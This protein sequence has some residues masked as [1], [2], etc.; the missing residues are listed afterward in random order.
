[1]AVARLLRIRAALALAKVGDASGVPAL[2]EALDHCDD[3]LLWRLILITLGQLRDRRAVPALLLHL[4]E[5]QNRREMVDA[6]GA[7]GDPAACDA[8]V[9]RLRGDSYVPVRVQAAKA[10]AKLGEPS[11]I[12]A[13]ERAATQ[14]TEAPVA[15]AAREA[16]AALGPRAPPTR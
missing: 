10:L 7:I 2:N 4:P 8:L 16:L 12:P 6:L 1:P 9:E 5:V 3:V 13:L 11:V 14:E 15:A